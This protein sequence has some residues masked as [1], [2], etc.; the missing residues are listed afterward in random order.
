MLV[1]IDMPPQVGL[2]FNAGSQFEMNMHL[3]NTGSDTVKPVIKLNDVTVAY[4]RHPAVHH[5]SG[6]F[7]QGSMTA[8]AGPN[9]AGKS[10]LLKAIMGELPLAEGSIDRCGLSA[11]DFG[12]LPQA[13]EID[14]QL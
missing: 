10:T 14:R 4:A 3:V 8:I 12:Y 13:A 7:R 2:P 5:V 1:G 6:S 9:G 11:C